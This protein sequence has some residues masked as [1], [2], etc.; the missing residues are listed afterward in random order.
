[1]HRVFA[2]STLKGEVAERVLAACDGPEARQCL[3]GETSPRSSPKA[4]DEGERPGVFLSSIEVG[5]FRGI[6][7]PQRLP[8]KP[9]SGLTV[10]VGRNGSGKSSF[11]EGLEFLLTRENH[12][13]KH[14]RPKVWRDGWRNLHQPDPA[15]LRAEFLLEGEPGPKALELKRS[16]RE[17]EALALLRWVLSGLPPRRAPPFR[18]PT[19][20]GLGSGGAWRISSSPCRT[21]GP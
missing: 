14:P 5:G 12:R 15:F 18:R 9:G 4:A 6:G 19:G 16:G 7:A 13:W 8:V 2:D 20:A 11:A 10:I 17:V 21:S 1:M 3:S